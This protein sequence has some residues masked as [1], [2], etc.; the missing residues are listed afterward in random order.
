MSVQSMGM[1]MRRHFVVPQCAW[2]YCRGLTETHIRGGASKSLPAADSCSANGLLTWSACSR[3]VKRPS[4]FPPQM[5]PSRGMR[6]FYPQFAD[7][8]GGEC[9]FLLKDDLSNC[10]ILIAEF[11]QVCYDGR[12]YSV[13]DLIGLAVERHHFTLM[14]RYGAVC[15]FH[16]A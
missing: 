8:E 10:R 6:L 11:H 5:I 16:R 1:T 7:I 3:T 4:S 13:D 15:A 12:H 14:Q 2:R 9:G